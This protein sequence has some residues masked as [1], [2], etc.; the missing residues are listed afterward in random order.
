MLEES[1]QYP[2][3]YIVLT[4][5]LNSCMFQSLKFVFLNLFVYQQLEYVMYAFSFSCCGP[6]LQTVVKE[7][8]ILIYVVPIS[9]MY[10]SRTRGEN[11]HSFFCFFFK[12][13]QICKS[14]LIRNPTTPKAVPDNQNSHSLQITRQSPGTL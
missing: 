8:M 2:V 11:E 5:L 4:I 3:T 12:A 13:F 1:Q 10:A 6:N 14:S 7:L 9:T